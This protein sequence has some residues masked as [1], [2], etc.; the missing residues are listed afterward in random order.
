M[1][2]SRLSYQPHAECGAGDK[3]LWESEG[4]CFLLL[5]SNWGR[6]CGVDEPASAT[7]EAIGK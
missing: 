1:F 7:G 6:V 5:G 4:R 2:R 3:W